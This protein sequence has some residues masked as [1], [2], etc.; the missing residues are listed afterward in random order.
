MNIQSLL[1]NIKES[2]KTT[3]GILNA[4]K[5]I[6]WLYKYSAAK[7]IICFT[8]PSV[9]KSVKLTVRNNKGADAFIVSEV[10]EHQCYEL[11]TA[12]NFS[13]ILD[14]GANA[15]FTTVY[16]SLLFPAA[17]I[18][19]VEPIPANIELLYENLVLNQIKAKVFEAAIAVADGEIAMELGE[20]D[21]SNK[22][23]DIPYGKH[24]GDNTIQVR[25]LTIET[26]VKELKW[27][28]IDLVKIDIEG[29]EGIL[30]KV[31]NA[32]LNL[33][34]T[35]IMEI[36]EGINPGQIGE[37]LTEFGFC[38][39]KESRGNWIFSKSEIN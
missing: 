2:F 36:H 17:T 7:T 14:L 32:W 29:Y 1:K 25:A 37:L 8:Y 24:L 39:Q 26:I 30:L 19:C 10:F 21:Y 35:L 27:P 23:H 9:G 16:F 31:N 5:K 38:H 20:M 34:G 33:T 3:A 6:F 22:V 4:L 28:R 15:G 12:G 11:G 13:Y 18:A